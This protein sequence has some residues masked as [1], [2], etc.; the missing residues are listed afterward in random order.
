MEQYEHSIGDISS[1]SSDQRENMN[2]DSDSICYELGGS[3]CSTSS[4]TTSLASLSKSSI[5]CTS[6]EIPKE[7]VS[8]KSIQNGGARPIYAMTYDNDCDRTPM[9]Y[10]ENTEVIG[11]NNI[12]G[13]RL[14]PDNPSSE[15][16]TSYSQK[17]KNIEY[18]LN[19]P[20]PPEMPKD[21]GDPERIPADKNH[22]WKGAIHQGKT[23]NSWVLLRCMGHHELQ[24]LSVKP[25]ISSLNQIDTFILYFPANMALSGTSSSLNCHDVKKSNRPSLYKYSSRIIY[26]WLG[27]ESSDLKRNVIIRLAL[28]IQANELNKK[29]T[30]VPIDQRS[31][32][33]LALEKF[34][35]RLNLCYIGENKNKHTMG[36]QH[37]L[38]HCGLE[39]PPES[40][41]YERMSSANTDVLFKKLSTAVHTKP[42]RDTEAIM[43]LFIFKAKLYKFTSKSFDPIVVS[44]GREISARH[45]LCIECSDVVVLDAFSDIFV[46]W[47][48]S[49]VDRQSLYKA[50]KWAESLFFTR[51]KSFKPYT[52]DIK[53]WHEICGR[54]H[55]LFRT[56]FPDWPQAF[57][58]RPIS[59]P[60]GLDPCRSIRPVPL[61]IP[62]RVESVDNSFYT[63]KN[64]YHKKPL[65]D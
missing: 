25:S 2:L 60:K 18:I 27:S 51:S 31:G 59:L 22:V 40:N 8:M 29:S 46:W 55:I 48:E 24:V 52:I 7:D 42:A 53:V 17:L 16:K 19:I 36:H 47:K 33:T 5:S 45:L 37:Y 26:V 12:H 63:G 32:R 38:E 50:I 44:H 4:S 65:F 6:M 1:D 41:S 61:A 64:L 56:K 35:V 9:K 13:P 62:K 58:T 30:I 10:L 21:S 3:E 34:L 11:D 39:V 28:E 20:R 14:T 23:T 54:E 15:N 43:K 49:S 57:P